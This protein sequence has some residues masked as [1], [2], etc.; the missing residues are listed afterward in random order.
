M[1]IPFDSGILYC[2]QYFLTSSTVELIAPCPALFSETSEAH[3][4]STQPIKLTDS[5]KDDLYLEALAGDVLQKLILTGE[6]L[7]LK[8]WSASQ[9]CNLLSCLAFE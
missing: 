4:V 6:S 8:C 3:V 5:L 2:V 1:L 9:D 7:R